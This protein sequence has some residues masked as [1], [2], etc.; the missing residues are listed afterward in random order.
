MYKYFDG[1]F[2]VFMC[3]KDGLFLI[4][5]YLYVCMYIYMYILYNCVLIRSL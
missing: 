3:M 1:R 2:F 5:M 4:E